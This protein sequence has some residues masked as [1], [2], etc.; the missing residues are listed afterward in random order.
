[1]SRLLPVGE[2][3]YTLLSQVKQRPAQKIILVVTVNT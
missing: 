1:M 2:P 3:K